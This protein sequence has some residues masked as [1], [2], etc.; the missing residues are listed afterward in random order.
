MKGRN[1]L[2]MLLYLKIV[3]LPLNCRNLLEISCMVCHR[4][5]GICW[6]AAGICWKCL[7]LLE[8]PSLICL[9]R[10]RKGMPSLIC[11]D[12]HWKDMLSKKFA[13]RDWL[14]ANNTLLGQGDRQIT[15][16]CYTKRGARSTFSPLAIQ[17]LAISSGDGIFIATVVKMHARLGTLGRKLLEMPWSLPVCHRRWKDMLFN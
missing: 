14:A 8:M 9:D 17:P 4:T 5:A 6:A 16:Y 3:F 2:E 11:L 10:H 13:I 7:D 12:R 1:L 15:I